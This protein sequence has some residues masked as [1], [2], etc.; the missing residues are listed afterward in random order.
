MERA[1]P[2]VELPPASVVCAPADDARTDIDGVELLPGDDGYRH[3]QGGVVGQRERRYA[4][5][6]L[7]V[8][9]IHRGIVAGA[10]SA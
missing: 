5:D 8:P 3:P 2:A 7:A 6:G 4:T 9:I 10:R 1:V